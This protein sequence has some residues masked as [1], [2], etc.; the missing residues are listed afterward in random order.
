MEPFLQWLEC[1]LTGLRMLGGCEVGFGYMDDVEVLSGNL[2]DL[3]RVDM[4]CC[5]FEAA[6]GAIQNCNRKMVL[7]GLGGPA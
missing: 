3:G 5:R 2:D 6:A 1:Y 4:L 7:L